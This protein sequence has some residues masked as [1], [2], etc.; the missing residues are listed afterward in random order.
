MVAPL[1]FDE[2]WSIVESLFP[3]PKPRPK[4]GRPPIDDRAAL[5]GIIVVLK[6]VGRVRRATSSICCR[7]REMPQA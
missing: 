1:A 6:R 3:A 4:V 7:S 5:T 2:L